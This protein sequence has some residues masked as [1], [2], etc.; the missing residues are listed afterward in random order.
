MKKA[1]L[2]T[3]MGGL[4]LTSCYR[5]LYRAEIVHDP[6]LS[7]QGEFTANASILAV[8]VYNFP[9]FDL[10]LGYSP[11]KN[12]GIKA[13]LR[14]RVFG[15]SGSFDNDDYR[16]RMYGTTLEGGIGYYNRYGSN[17]LFSVYANVASGYNKDRSY[18]ISNGNT[19]NQLNS[20]FWAFSIQPAV[21]M[22]K[23]KISMMG[24]VKVGVYKFFDI[25]SFDAYYTQQEYNNIA[26]NYYPI[27]EPYYIFEV[28]PRNVKFNFQAGFA[29]APGGPDKDENFF[30]PKLSLGIT[31]RFG[32]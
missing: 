11:V 30:T 28:G 25:S 6:M 26:K 12:I 1:L 14:N 22:V 17:G 3:T 2:F 15:T 24:G 7:Q 13:S 23:N 20:K 4:L 16:R 27:I 31:A 5:P 32:K 8:G 9:S 10:G 18:Y 21:G 29:L 19:R